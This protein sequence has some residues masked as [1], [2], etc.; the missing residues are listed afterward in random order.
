M[1]A[2]APWEIGRGCALE[3]KQAMV[4]RLF[5]RVAVVFTLAMLL[6]PALLAAQ[7]EDRH[8]IDAVGIGARIFGEALR[9]QA[10]GDGAPAA[11]LLS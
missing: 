7:P 2:D 1:G 3:D 11:A 9:A 6:S 4:M 8:R 5:Q 10:D